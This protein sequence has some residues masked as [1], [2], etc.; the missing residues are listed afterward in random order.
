MENLCVQLFNLQNNT[1]NQRQSIL[2]LFLHRSLYF[3]WPFFHPFPANVFQM[4]SGPCFFLS[5]NRNLPTSTK[6]K[7]NFQKKT[8]T[9]QNNTEKIAPSGEMSST[10]LYVYAWLM[11][12]HILGQPTLLKNQWMKFERDLAWCQSSAVH[13]DSMCMWKFTVWAFYE[14]RGVAICNEWVLKSVVTF[15]ENSPWRNRLPSPGKECKQWK[16][17][18]LVYIQQLQTLSKQYS[19]NVH[20]CVWRTV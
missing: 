6:R 7:S 10:V 16:L 1:W 2:I 4:S 3:F 20:N 19:F 8:L 15:V 13:V 9:L 18:S 17:R 14:A 11:N 5:I 12:I